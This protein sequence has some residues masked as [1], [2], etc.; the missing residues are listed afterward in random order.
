MLANMVGEVQ[1]EESDFGRDSAKVHLIKPHHGN[2]SDDIVACYQEGVGLGSTFLEYIW[3]GAT[4]A[5]IGEECIGIYRFIVEHYT[6]EHEIWLFG[7]SRGSFTCRCVAGMINNCGIMKRRK[8][9]LSEPEVERLCYDIFRKY[10][11]NLPTDAPKSDS[12]KRLRGDA[13]KI[14]QVKQPIR[15][16]SIIDTVGALGIPRLSAGIGLDWGPLEF[17]DQRVSSAVQYTHH[18]VSLH[19]RLWAF[20]PCLI[21]PSDCP[22]DTTSVVNQR[23]FPGTHYDLGRQAFRFIRQSPMNRV[24]A[25][26]GWL[27]N[28]LSRTI[29][30]NEV[31]GDN[32][33]KWLL[34][35][36]LEVGGNINPIIPDARNEIHTVNARLMAPLPNSTGSGDI[37][38]NVL[39]YAPA[40]RLLGLI[41]QASSFATSLL[42]KVFPQLGDNIQDLLGIRT[43]LGI[44]LATV[45]RRIP[46][47]AADVDTY[48][49][50]RFHMGQKIGSI[51]ELAKMTEKNN[52]GT[53]RYPSRAHE[54]F[55]LW[56]KVFGV[57]TAGAAEATEQK[58]A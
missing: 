30:P 55:L 15:C 14:W 7:F 32:V 25:L 26:L 6:D 52:K 36:I 16:M 21:F 2:N 29:W 53:E 42:N 19:D 13:E 31:L 22:C 47:I 1:A 9:E 41:Q 57:E 48:K 4:A 39:D 54:G 5:T 43:I 24:E 27:P 37:Y 49:S 11:S 10:R 38:G 8:G 56:K 33:L 35:G 12:C 28:L 44:L 18:A 17:F 51:E 50:S 20:Q 45:D 40:G 46:G 3:D 34:E 23:W 58:H